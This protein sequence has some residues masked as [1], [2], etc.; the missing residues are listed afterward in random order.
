MNVRRLR[1]VLWS[2]LARGI[3][4]ASIV[5]LAA[6]S[7]SAPREDVRNSAEDGKAIT[8]LPGQAFARNN[9]APP[10]MTAAGVAASAVPDP[11][12]IGAS[13]RNSLYFS[14]NDATLDEG[15]ASVLRQYAEQLRRNPKRRVVLKAYLDNQGSRSYSLA[16]VQ[17]R[18]D[19]VTAVLREKGVPRSRI[20]QIMLGL[21]GKK[22]SCDTPLCLSRR[23]SIELQYR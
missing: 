12:A 17:Q 10:A 5:A 7:S 16:I 9:P 14:D 8:S 13:A 18:L 23:N 21:S 11:K 1:K 4:L 2:A 22:L 15:S 3:P 19:A 6:C 20:R